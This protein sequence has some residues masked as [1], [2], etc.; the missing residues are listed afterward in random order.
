MGILS[1]L[2]FQAGENRKEA[3]GIDKSPLTFQPVIQWKGVWLCQKFDL[4]FM[5]EL[6]HLLH[7]VKQ[8]AEFDVNT[9]QWP[10]L[11][12]GFSFSWDGIEMTKPPPRRACCLLL[13]KVTWATESR[14]CTPARARSR[15][16]PKNLGFPEREERGI[17]EATA[18]GL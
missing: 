1:H 8:A 15:G 5:T 13:D 7:F 6:G 17:F 3:E 4:T 2:S 14:G 9:C 11:L 12:K 16:R 10:A 18:L